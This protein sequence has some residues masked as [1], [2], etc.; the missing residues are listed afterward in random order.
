MKGEEARN[1]LN[2]TSRPSARPP[3][4]M[5]RLEARGVLT[6]HPGQGV[7]IVPHDGV[8][9]GSRFEASPGVSAVVPGAGR[10]VLGERTFC[11]TCA[12]T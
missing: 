3:E 8:G 12:G 11:V 7:G 6:G 9:P 4:L 5:P 1:K 10:A 2:T